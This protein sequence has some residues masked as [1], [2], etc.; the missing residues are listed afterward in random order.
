LTAKNGQ[1]C[2]DGKRECVSAPRFPWFFL[3]HFPRP[4]AIMPSASNARSGLTHPSCR[5]GTWNR[6]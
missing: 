2:Q 1:G 3:W 5:P 6:G 4:L